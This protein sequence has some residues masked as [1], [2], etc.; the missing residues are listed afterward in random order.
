MCLL[1]QRAKCAGE[2]RGILLLMLP[3]WYAAQVGPKRHRDKAAINRWAAAQVG[4]EID[5]E[6]ISLCE[7]PS[8]HIK[9][10][11]KNAEKREVV[12]ACDTDQTRL[13]RSGM[14]SCMR[15]KIIQII[16]Q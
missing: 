7:S 11:I 14:V 9:N 3:C 13:R 2:T 6:L 4:T 5:R 16:Y 8:H 15:A 10:H 1:L 12:C